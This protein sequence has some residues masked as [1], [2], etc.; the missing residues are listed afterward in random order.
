MNKKGSGFIWFIVAIVFI[1]LL[2]L[3]VPSAFTRLVNWF[4]RLIGR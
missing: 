3:F 2:F 4:A 1:L